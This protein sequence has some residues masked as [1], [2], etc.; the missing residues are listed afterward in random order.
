MN[1]PAN[2]GF[3]L[4]GL[5]PARP[6]APALIAPDVTLSLSKL[7]RLVD[8]FA[9]R[10]TE[11]GIG[12]GARVGLATGDRIIAVA[13]LFAAALVGAEFTTVDHFLLR[14]PALR[15][16]HFLR[17]A[18]TPGLQGVPF[19]LMDPSWPPKIDGQRCAQAGA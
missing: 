1:G 17:S 19:Q 2:I 12:Q 6:D 15:P 18:E 11:A 4:R 8:C 7:W 5:A 3:D 14:V 16:T 10:M 9:C 13:G